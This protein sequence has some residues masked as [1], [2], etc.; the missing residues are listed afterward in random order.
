MPMW[1]HDATGPDNHHPAELDLDVGTDVP[2]VIPIA[3]F[4]LVI[5]GIAFLLATSSGGSLATAAPL[6]RPVAHHAFTIPAVRTMSMFATC[7]SPQT[8]LIGPTTGPTA[9]TLAW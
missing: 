2:R 7:G 1:E 5:A 3:V 9:A 8:P 6:T 4:I